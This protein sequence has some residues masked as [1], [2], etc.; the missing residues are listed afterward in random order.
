M[1]PDTSRG[2]I[3]LWPDDWNERRAG[4]GCQACSQ[5]RP[6][7]DAHG[8]R[9]FAGVYADAYLKRTTP[10]LAT[11]LK[12]QLLVACNLDKNIGAP[13]RA[14]SEASQHTPPT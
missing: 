6:D 9:W 5:G 2:P 13:T 11:P 12:A 14:A 10:A 8:I 1:R 4:M 7:E 3:R